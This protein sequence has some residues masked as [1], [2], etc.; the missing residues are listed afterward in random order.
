MELSKQARIASS[1]IVSAT[2]SLI[3]SNCTDSIETIQ[4]SPSDRANLDVD[5]MMYVT[6]S[7][8]SIDPD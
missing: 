3:Q 4:A 1:H 8:I 5:T 2:D 7:S 6:E